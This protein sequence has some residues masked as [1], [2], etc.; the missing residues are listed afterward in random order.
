LSLS[1]NGVPP[2][3]FCALH[4]G[5]GR[6][7]CDKILNSVAVLLDERILVVPEKE[8]QGQTA[9]RGKRE[10]E[11]TQLTVSQLTGKGTNLHAHLGSDSSL[12]D[13]RR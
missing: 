3:D 7:V 5:Y 12:Q 13:L 11:E 1:F 2:D 6:G 9:C 4:H 10:E 8:R